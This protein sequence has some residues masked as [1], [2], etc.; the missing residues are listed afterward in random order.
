MIL[1]IRVVAKH[2]RRS[3]S[4][5]FST[6]NT[7]LTEQVQNQA[8]WSWSRIALLDVVLIC[9]RSR[10][11]PPRMPYQ[12]FSHSNSHTINIFYRILQLSETLWGE[13]CK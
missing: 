4:R 5:V 6:L 1:F 7:L 9:V 8:I 12:T 3:P 10:K 2:F 11:Q 13:D